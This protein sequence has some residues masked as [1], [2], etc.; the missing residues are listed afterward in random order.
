MLLA[1][2]EFDSRRYPRVPGK[3]VMRRFD[4]AEFSGTFHASCDIVGYMQEYLN[5]VHVD[6]DKALRL[7]FLMKFGTPLKCTFGEYVRRIGQGVVY[8]SFNN[9]DFA[10]EEYSQD[11]YLRSTMTP[12]SQSEWL[13]NMPLRTFRI[14]GMTFKKY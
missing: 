11:Y 13:R 9:T 6:R 2:N 14:F 12:D 10:V 5:Q 1:M 8:Y 4:A 7:F 3:N